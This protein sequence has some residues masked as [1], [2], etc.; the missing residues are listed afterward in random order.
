MGLGPENNGVV[1]PVIPDGRYDGRKRGL[2]TVA[3]QE[4]KEKKIKKENSNLQLPRNV[5]L[6][7]DNYLILGVILQTFPKVQNFGLPTQGC[8]LSENLVDSVF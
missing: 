4:L 2:G 3:P 5:I 8:R 7:C 1:N 6:D